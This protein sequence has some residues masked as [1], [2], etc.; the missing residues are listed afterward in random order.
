MSRAPDEGGE[1]VVTVTRRRALLV[2][3]V[4][5]AVSAV[6]TLLA[7]AL[8]RSPAEIAARSAP[9]EPTPI[10]AAVE[11]RVITTDVVSRGTARFG[12]PRALSVVRSGLKT[13]PQVVTSLPEAGA[14]LAEGAVVLTVSGR[15]VFLLGGERP[16]YRDLGPGMTGPDVEQ[17]EAAL[18][19]L[20][21]GPGPVDGR[22]DGATGRAVQELYRRAG[23]PALTAT[24]AQLDAARPAEAAMIDGARASA[25]VQLPADE[26]VIVT[27]PPVRVSEVTA[28][29]GAEPAGPLVTVTD[30]Q[31]AVD[32]ALTLD[33]ARQVRA[34]M[35]VAIDEPTLGISAAGEV[36]RVADRPGTD[37]ADGF[38][39]H[40][41][42]V[43]P[44]PPPTLVGASVRLT[45]PVGSTGRPVPAVPVSAVSLAPDGSSR[46]EVARDGRTGFV[47]V[48]TGLA[49]DGYVQVTAPDGGLAAGDR[50]VIGVAAAG[51]GN[52]R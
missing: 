49:G 15:P 5:V 48:V 12:S 46:V 31:V 38:H 20:G 36:A 41:E 18:R 43:V 40:V 9:P 51:P 14:E 28:V 19:R 13:G 42:I 4:V 27:R 16:A 25:G 34:G 29:L 21:L 10:L 52:G 11:E 30:S 17:L 24:S 44:Q 8:V 39:V 32:A 33:E 7:T 3:A 26:V 2:V 50:V 22:Y 35:P 23:A 37:G 1:S 6:A 45:V 47:T